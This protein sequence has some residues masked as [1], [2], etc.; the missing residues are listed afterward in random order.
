MHKHTRLV[1]WTFLISLYCLVT[2]SCIH[3]SSPCFCLFLRDRKDQEESK[4]LLETEA[5]WGKGWGNERAGGQWNQT[6]MRIHR[7]LLAL[8]WVGNVCVCGSV[9]STVW[10]VSYVTGRGWL[11]RK[12]NWRL[13][14]FPGRYLEGY[15]L[16]ETFCLVSCN[17]W[18]VCVSST[19]LPWPTWRSW[20]AGKMRPSTTQLQRAS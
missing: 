14:W 19:G 12:W 6:K 3:L 4:E 16:Y 10:S 18:C 2:V 5:W 17:L 13:P 1:V 20:R 8:H 11:P 7:W 15:V 9:T